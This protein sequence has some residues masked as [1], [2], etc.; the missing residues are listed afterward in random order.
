MIYME[1]VNYVGLTIS[2]YMKYIWLYK[3][4][5]SILYTTALI[6]RKYTGSS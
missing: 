3:Y 4:A 1:K 5:L 6:Y 2:I